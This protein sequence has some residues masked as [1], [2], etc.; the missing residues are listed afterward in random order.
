MASWRRQIY[1]PPLTTCSGGPS[2][3]LWG[4]GKLACPLS[5]RECTS[6]RCR[7]SWFDGINGSLQFGFEWR[8]GGGLAVRSRPAVGIEGRVV[9]RSFDH[10]AG[11]ARV[12]FAGG[13]RFEPG[14]QSRNGRTTRR[15]HSEPLGAQATP[16]ALPGGRAAC[17]PRWALNRG[18]RASCL[19]AILEVFATCRPLGS[20]RSLSDVSQ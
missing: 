17:L 14:R 3:R 5:W 1:S 11:V 12:F 7:P 18:R 6:V 15:E 8:V 9:A 20:R 19:G 13:L 16:G 4:A 2:E 10:S